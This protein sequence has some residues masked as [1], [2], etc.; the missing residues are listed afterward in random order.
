M[1]LKR[2]NKVS[3]YLINFIIQFVDK[4]SNNSQKTKGI[5]RP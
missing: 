3:G 5:T 1:A 4:K 2:I